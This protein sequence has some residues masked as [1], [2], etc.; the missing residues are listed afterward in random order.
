MTDN[1]KVAEEVRQDAQ[2]VLAGLA[3]PPAQGP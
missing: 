3:E 2:R 1:F